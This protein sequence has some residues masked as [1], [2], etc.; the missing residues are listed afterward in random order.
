[1]DGFRNIDCACL[2]ESVLGVVVGGVV[3][4]VVGV[5]IT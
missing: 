5:V 1:M 2:V 3:G 4:G